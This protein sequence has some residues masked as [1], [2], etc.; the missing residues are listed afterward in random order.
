MTVLNHTS[1][2]FPLPIVIPV[3]QNHIA[4]VSPEDADLLG[5]SWQ[6]HDGNSNEYCR[7]YVKGSGK[8]GKHEYMHQ[9]ILSR[10]LGRPLEKGERPDHQ[11]RNGLNNQRW[12]LRLATHQQNTFN[13]GRKHKSPT[14]QYKGVS[15][16]GA[17]WDAVIMVDRK[18][19][20]LGAYENEVEAGIAYNH[21]A[22]QYFGEFAQ[23]NGIPEWEH[24][25]PEKQDHRHSRRDNK[26]GYPNI[27]REGKRWGAL[28]RLNGK[29]KYIGTFDTVEQ[30]YKAQCEAKE[31]YG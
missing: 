4:L 19:I 17:Y 13:S 9:V 21:A 14:S 24:V 28:I 31:K 29:Q 16:D 5:S 1:I 2:Q 3:S 30:A 26:S 8:N 22:A 18:H 7:R 25:Y 10:M 12:N 27:R 6:Y 23:F 15:R 20:Y 11:D